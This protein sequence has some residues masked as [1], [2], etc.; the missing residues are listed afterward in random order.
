MP[1]DANKPV[2]QAAV[3]DTVLFCLG[4][5]DL[6]P[7]LRMVQTEFA[8]IVTSV[9]GYGVLDLVYFLPPGT[10]ILPVDRATQVVHQHL[11]APGRSFWRYR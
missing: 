5:A 6:A 3:G 10:S 2:P 8:A 7:H 9:R 1:A 11:A 4:A